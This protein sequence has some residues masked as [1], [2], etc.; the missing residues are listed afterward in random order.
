VTA[1]SFLTP[2]NNN[3]SPYMPC[4]RSH[5]TV[6]RGR[7]RHSFV[8]VYIY[9]HTFPP[10]FS[11]SFFFSLVSVHAPTYGLFV[12]IY[13]FI[14]PCCRLIVCP[15][16]HFAQVRSFHCTAISFNPFPSAIHLGI[17]AILR[18][19]YSYPHCLHQLLPRVFE[20]LAYHVAVP[21]Y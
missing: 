8:A 9:E 14:S 20:L 2:L 21:S 19:E 7:P 11:S 6:L 18:N 3:N 10:P 16:T 5:K 13:L 1:I 15:F 4:R 12:R 17:Y